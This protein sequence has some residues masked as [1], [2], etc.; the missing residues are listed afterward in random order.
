[1]QLVGGSAHFLQAGDLNTTGR[2]FS[3][4]PFHAALLGSGTNAIDIHSGKAKHGAE[5]SGTRLAALPEFRQGTHMQTI[6]VGMG[7][8]WGAEK[9]F[10]STPGVIH[11]EVGYQGGTM[12]NPDYKLVCTGRTGHAEI[13]KVDYDESVISTRAVLKVFWENH[14]PTQGDRQGN[15]IGS[16]YRSAV[17][18]TNPEQLAIAQQTKTE[19]AD[20]LRAAGLPEITTEIADA[21]SL[22][23]WPAEEYHQKYLQK[24][25]NGYDCHA[26]TGYNLPA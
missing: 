11:T 26:L 12:P 9:R 4:Q 22:P 7:C 8:F 21:N 20:V 18:C 17:Y 23:Y 6:Y 25:P 1:M 16:Q 19:F 13:V 15:D 2:E 14:D 24:N 10:W 3:A 5:G